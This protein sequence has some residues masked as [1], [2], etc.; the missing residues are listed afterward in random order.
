M[1]EVTGTALWEFI[2]V[3]SAVHQS[4]RGSVKN[5]EDVFEDGLILRPVQGCHLEHTVEDGL[6]GVATAIL[7]H[8][9]KEFY[10]FIAGCELQFWK[11]LIDWLLLF[12]FKILRAFK[13]I[14]D[15]VL[16]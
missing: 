12:F 11:Y 7:L 9:L 3:V 6:W 16:G 14:F 10:G 4:V 15:K 2:A 8:V 5:V 1:G 13:E